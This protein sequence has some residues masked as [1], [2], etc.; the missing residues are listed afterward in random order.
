M[1]RALFFVIWFIISH[2]NCKDQYFKI[3]CTVTTAQF[4]GEGDIKLVSDVA[5]RVGCL[6]INVNLT[7]RRAF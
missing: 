3:S 7:A 4:R 2:D 6:R 1:L 5:G